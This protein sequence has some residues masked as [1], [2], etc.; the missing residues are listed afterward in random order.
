[1]VKTGG[2][3]VRKVEEVGEVALAE[4]VKATARS[5]FGERITGSK[6]M[7]LF[8]SKYE[9]GGETYLHTHEGE[10]GHYVLAGKFQLVTDE[11]EWVVEASTAVFIPPRVKHRFKNVGKTDAYMLAIFSPPESRYEKTTSSP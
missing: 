7:Q 5:L 8:Y 10:S 11:G 3:V 4:H 2:V 9:V 1:L 6:N